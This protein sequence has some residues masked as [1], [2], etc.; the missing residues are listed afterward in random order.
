MARFAVA[1]TIACGLVGC[2]VRGPETAGTD[3]PV[4]TAAPTDAAVASEPPLQRPAL[5]LSDPE[6]EPDTLVPTVRYPDINEISSDYIDDL[7]APYTTCGTS[8]PA[9]YG[10]PAVTIDGERFVHRRHDARWDTTWVAYAEYE[11]ER[12]DERYATIQRV[13]GTGKPVDLV[14]MKGRTP[15]HDPDSG[16]A[17]PDDMETRGLDC[18]QLEKEI[19]PALTKINATLGRDRWRPMLDA[20]TLGIRLVRSPDALA[21]LDAA[22]ADRTPIE[23][24]IVGG[25]LVFRLDGEPLHREPTTLSTPGGD[26]CANELYDL[27]IDL[28]TGLTIVSVQTACDVEWWFE[29]AHMIVTLPVAVAQTIADHAAAGRSVLEAED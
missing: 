16:L 22:G 21:E 1:L 12:F 10:F 23:L 3:A 15:P 11:D 29:E 18:K 4:A 28:P 6:L 25:E 7:W 20:P 5:H 8:V 19:E 26:D 9:A 27:R 2:R 17:G 13:D 24:S 14:L